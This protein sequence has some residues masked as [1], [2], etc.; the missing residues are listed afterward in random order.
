MLDLIKRVRALTLRLLPVEVAPEAIED[1][2]SRVITPQVI[3]AY[4]EA[5][6]DFVHAV[7]VCGSIFSGGEADTLSIAPVC[8]AQSAERVHVGCQYES[9]G[10]WREHG[11]RYACSAELLYTST[12]TPLLCS[13]RLRGPR[14]SRCPPRAV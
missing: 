5:A 7:S 4:I 2:T 12:D 8:P 1:P 13:Y 11:K 10:L 6:G 3:D 14:S 9:G